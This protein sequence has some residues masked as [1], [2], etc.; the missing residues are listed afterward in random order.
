MTTST[1]NPP[2]NNPPT[3]EDAGDRKT[4]EESSQASKLAVFVGLLPPPPQALSIE[5][6]NEVIC[7]AW[8]EE[9]KELQ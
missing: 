1:N 3:K 8:A 7:A 5:E 2:T 9:E 4:P 6:M